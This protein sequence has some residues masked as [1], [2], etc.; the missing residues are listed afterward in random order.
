MG[1]KVEE[2][3]DYLESRHQE[4]EWW[5]VLQSNR[6]VAEVRIGTTRI[7]NAAG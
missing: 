5:Q 4:V 1:V 7:R 6:E 3:E 2:S